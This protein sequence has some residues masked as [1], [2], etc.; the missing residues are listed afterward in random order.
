MIRINRILCPIDFSQFSSHA[1]DRAVGL[2]RAYGA[3]IC[4][5]HVLPAAIPVPAVPYGPEGPGPFAVPT[6][7]RET[8]LAEIPRFLATERDIGVSIDYHVV[9]APSVHKEI[10]AQAELLS[11]DVVV[12]GSHGRSG[13][14]RLMLGS[15]AE[16]LLRSSPI[17][18]LTVPSHVPDAVP[19]G[20]DPFRAILYA[21]D[22]SPGS[23]AALPYAASLAQHAAAQLTVMHVVE[24]I[25][26][27]YDPMGGSSFDVTAY[28]T[29]LE[30]QARAKLRTT[31]PEWVRLGCQTDDVVTTG[32]PYVQILRAA[33]ERLI[34]LIVMGVHGRNALDRLVFGSTTEHIIRRA[35][36]PVLTV[37][38]R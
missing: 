23:D 1:F 30:N 33:S 20:R 18:I 32:K 27:G 22:F 29:G 2:A 35:T 31:I 10:L 6:F 11:A 4:V 5:L 34:D 3:T 19:M 12:V 17:P 37:R 24:P 25:P 15:V 38:E 16:K 14:D 26:I 13:F 28:H 7:D 9:D 21:T 8:A 36:C